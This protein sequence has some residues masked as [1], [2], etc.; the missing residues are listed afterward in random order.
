[1]INIIQKHCDFIRIEPY[2]RFLMQL[3]HLYKQRRVLADNLPFKIISIKATKRRH[4]SCKSLFCVRDTFFF[5]IL[6]DLQIFLVFLN[7]Y[8]LQAFQI[9]YLKLF[10][11]IIFINRIILH[12]EMKENTDIIGIR[13]P[14]PRRCRW[15]HRT[16]IILCKWRQCLQ[17]LSET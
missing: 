6:I 12:K 13:N 9:M 16:K 2:N 10:D 1:M 14:G 15:F 17:D 8:R 3:R 11:R 7:I 4:L 5:V